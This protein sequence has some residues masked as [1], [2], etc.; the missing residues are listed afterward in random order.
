MGRKLLSILI[1][2]RNDDYLGNYTYRLQTCLNFLAQNLKTLGR[3]DD[4]EVVLVDWNS[5]GETLADVLKV[6]PEAA[7]ILRFVIVPPAVAYA[8][9]PLASFFT[10]CAVNVGVRRAKGEFIMLADSDSMMPLPALESLLDILSGKLPTAQPCNELI[11]PIPRHQIPGGIGARKP[12]VEQWSKILVRIY[13]SRRKESPGADSLG[14]FSAA[15]LMHRDIWMEVGGYNELLNRAW[16]WS[17]NDLMLRVTQKFGWMDLGYYGVAAFHIEHNPRE[18]RVGERDPDSINA[19]TVTYEMKP[20]DDDWGLANVDLPEAT[21]KGVSNWRT[22]RSYGADM[23]YTL[24]TADA[25]KEAIEDD[26]DLQALFGILRKRYAFAQDFEPYKEDSVKA[27]AAMASFEI[28]LGAYYFGEPEDAILDALLECAPGAEVY[29][30]QPW[31]E[32]DVSARPIPPDM[33]SSHLNFCNHRGF[34]RVLSLPVFDAIDRI[35]STDPDAHPMEMAIIDRNRLGEA[36]ERVFPQILRV[37]A[38]GGAVILIDRNGRTPSDD[39]AASIFVGRLLIAYD[40][41][42]QSG[43]LSRRPVFVQTDD[44]AERGGA[45]EI[46][47]FPSG[48]VHV[49]RKRP[50]TE[51]TRQLLAAE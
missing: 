17:D 9:N 16:G 20:N 35:R 1:V 8:R 25:I 48:Q 11:F 10:T 5:A 41:R 36:F 31:P 45:F 34:S 26:S 3:L 14:G 39:E 50:D 42:E 24:T 15:Q 4:V 23:G 43:D 12:S 40:R 27:V 37:M 46:A 47:T 2:G 44:E 38:P 13:G 51:K 49:I 19:M 30:V 22:S 21:I 28:P 6:S 29:F 33:F 18:R 32:G 7:S